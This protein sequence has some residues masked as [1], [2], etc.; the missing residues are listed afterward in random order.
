MKKNLKVIGLLAG[1]SMAITIHAGSDELYPH[2]KAFP[3]DPTS[4]T[5]T[6]TTVPLDSSVVVMLMS[7]ATVALHLLHSSK[8][9]KKNES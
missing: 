4:S 9:K 8:K 3:G 1:L 5:T 6:G 2:I 7:G